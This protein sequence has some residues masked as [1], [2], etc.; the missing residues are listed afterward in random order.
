MGTVREQTSPPFILKMSVALCQMQVDAGARI[1]LAKK[2]TMYETLYCER[3]M[4]L[5]ANC[6]Q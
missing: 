5:L 2:D 3:E 1:Q 4:L 6:F